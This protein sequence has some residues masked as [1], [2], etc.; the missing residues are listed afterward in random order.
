MDGNTPRAEAER[1]LGIAVKLLT[2]RDFVG[3]KTFAIRA[4]ESDPNN[5]VSDQVLA[6]VET[7]LAGEKRVN[8]A[9]HPD[10]YTVLQL[11]RLVRDPELIS[12][13][14]RRLEALLGPER[15]R[16]PFAEYAFQLVTDAWSILSDPNKKWLF[17]NE[18]AAYLQRVVDG[19]RLINNNNNNNV[20]Q[21]LPL[22]QAGAA[23]AAA[24]AVQQQQ[25]QPPVR[26]EAVRVESASASANSQLNTFQFFQQPAQAPSSAAMWQQH[27]QEVNLN[28]QNFFQQQQHNVDVNSININNNNNIG[29]GGGGGGVQ[30]IEFMQQQP[31]AVQLLP[32]WQMRDP[33]P[34]KGGGGGERSKGVGMGGLVGGTGAQP[35]MRVG[36]VGVGVGPGVSMGM[37]DGQGMG[38]GGGGR[39]AVVRETVRVSGNVMNNDNVVVDD[40]SRKGS[41]VNVNVGGMHVNDDVVVNNDGIGDDV[42]VGVDE[43]GDVVIDGGKEGG[44]VGGGEEGEEEKD[45]FWT[46]CPYCLYI[47]EYEKVYQEC[48][49]RCQNCRRGFQA[50]QIPNPP[51][52]SGRG[53]KQKE[54]SFCCWGF[55]PLGFS[56]VAW[57]K[58]NRMGGSNWVPFSPMFPTPGEKGGGDFQWF[59]S[60]GGAAVGPR[61]VGRPPLS[62]PSVVVVD[63]DGD[64]NS[65]PSDSD[66]SDQDWRRNPALEKKKKIKKRGRVWKGGR[67]RPRKVKEQVVDDVQTQANDNSVVEDGVAAGDDALEN[68][69]NPQNVVVG[70]T[71]GA[72]EE[73][74]KKVSTT[75][76]RNQI[77]RRMKNMGKLDL[78]VEFNNEG[79]EHAPTVSAVNVGGDGVENIEF[80]EG[81]DE[82]L[83][84]LP[85]LNVAG[86]EKA[87]PS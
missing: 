68:G 86:E 55:F 82:F 7:I 40:R 64:F 33:T 53:K 13:H 67:G 24:A 46:S 11:P 76:T 26:V 37:M 71:A 9:Q 85:I 31:Q 66:S 30:Q 69:S 51:P 58:Q 56:A 6:V 36:D 16:L 28:S 70:S 18:L 81:L 35:M 57:R 25:Q 12:G 52:I 49:L 10:W 87:K 38:Q 80:F 50:A 61:N 8:A 3:S 2:A 77:R 34:A 60:N 73:A 59:E 5:V 65:D 23:A 72:K 54:S 17:D 15:N 42:V 19:Q 20:N 29:G 32:Q 63:E 22:Q 48:T 78:N 44:D 39:G 27:Q 83:S 62:Q 4:K 79:D 43:D 47:F 84:T 14:H 75:L 45:A 21:P 41:N 74:R 1:W